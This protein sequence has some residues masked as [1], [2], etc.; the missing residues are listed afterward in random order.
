MTAAP[1][2]YLP[3][4]LVYLLE[5]VENL[6]A[7]E[8]AACALPL[9]E[10]FSDSQQKADIGGQL[11]R[12][13]SQMGTVEAGEALKALEVMERFPSYPRPRAAVAIA[14]L[15]GLASQKAA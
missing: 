5:G 9:L 10:R 1:S 7:A 15:R 12:G 8:V 4:E 2:Y 14:A 3:D 6:P 13:I 11:L